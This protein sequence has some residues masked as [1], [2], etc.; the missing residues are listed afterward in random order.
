VIPFKSIFAR[1]IFLHVIA[2][3]IAAIVMPLVLFWFVKSAAD[4]LHDQAMRE[5]AD[6]VARHLVL[7]AD[8]GWALELPPALQ[9]LYSQAYGRYAYAV[10]DG[11]GKVLFSSLSD[12]SPIFSQDLRSSDVAF[13]E[14]GR[15]NSASV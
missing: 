3:V 1:I 4:D 2:M 6:L 11:S 7:R 9:A 10:L 8:G 15:G 12:L 14:T 13:M 5:Q